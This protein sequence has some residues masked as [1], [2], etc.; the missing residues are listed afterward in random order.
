M[1]R[2]TASGRTDFLKTPKLRVERVD[3]KLNRIEGI[4]E[5]EHAQVNVRI[6]VARE[7]REPHFALPLRFIEGFEHAVLAVCELGIVIVRDGMNLPEVETIGPESPE[8]LLEHL[9]R[10]IR[11][12]TVRA[13]LGHQEHLVAI[14]AAKCD[15][16]VFFRAVVVVLPRVIAESDTAVD[17][18]VE[19][20]RGFGRG[21]GIA[22]VVATETE[23]RDHHARVTAELTKRNVRRPHR[24]LRRTRGGRGC[25]ETGE[26]NARRARQFRKER[27]T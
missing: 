13:D 20:A 25:R 12:A 15:T 27:S 14:A 4:P 19:D 1:P 16:H 3:R 9:H 18:L 23:R 10:E 24:L 5:L 17:R 8:R 6:L 2:L 21:R 26:A 7:A 22:E 11:V